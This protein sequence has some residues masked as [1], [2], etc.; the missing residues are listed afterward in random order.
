MNWKCLLLLSGLGFGLSLPV[1]AQRSNQSDQVDS[2]YVADFPEIAS[3]RVGVAQRYFNFNLKSKVD[4]GKKVF[5][6][7]NVRG[8]YGIGVYYR[9]LGLEFSVGLPAGDRENTLFGKTKS[10]DFQIN[11]YGQKLG[12]DVSFQSYRGFYQ[13]NP[14][15][16]DTQWSVIRGYPQRAD[17][18]ALNAGLNVYYIFNQSR[19]SYQAAFNQTERQLR[20]AGSPL[21]L[22][23]LFHSHLRSDSTLYP[24][25]GATPQGIAFEDGSFNILAFAPG[26][27]HTFVLNK[28]FYVSPSL[29]WGLALRQQAYRVDGRYQ[30]GLD[31]GQKV[32][33]RL[34][35]G[36]YGRKTFAGINV[37]LDNNRMDLENVRL[38]T[39]GVNI[40]FFAGYRFNRIFSH[41]VQNKTLDKLLTR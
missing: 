14:R 15:E 13:K 27:V 31:V 19:F 39:S 37:V 40:K 5:Y 26:Y 38:K 16:F 36:Y 35:A 6:A 24:V 21:L 33:F 9:K 3:A 8:T 32:N 20:S 2:D 41:N 34:A 17:L 23:S 10:F 7:P 28:D 22:G 12:Y 4:P 25:S 30:S 11:S 29:F 1:F 18:R